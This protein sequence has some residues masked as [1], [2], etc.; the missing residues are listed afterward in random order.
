VFNKFIKN[1]FGWIIDR[2]K[3]TYDLLIYW[4]KDVWKYVTGEVNKT[5]KIDKEQ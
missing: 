4:V 2:V 3:K 5:K 1:P